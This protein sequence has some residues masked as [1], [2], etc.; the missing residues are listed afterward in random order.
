M[1]DVY[2]LVA[3]AERDVY[4][5]VAQAYRE[6]DECLLVS[7]LWLE[8]WYNQLELELANTSSS[9]IPSLNS[10]PNNPISSGR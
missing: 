3:Q 7:D 2:P 5:L 8:Q 10:S 6:K 9:L 1:M 4:P